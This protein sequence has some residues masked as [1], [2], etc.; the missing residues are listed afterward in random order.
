MS[1]PAKLKKSLK[2]I[3]MQKDDPINKLILKELLDDQE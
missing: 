1:E 3:C 2:A